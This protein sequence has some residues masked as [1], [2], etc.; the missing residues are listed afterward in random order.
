MAKIAFI[1]AGSFGFTRTLVKDVLSFP[2]L[3]NATL[4][5]MDIDRERLDYIAQAARKIIEKGGYP[6]KVETTM[7]RREALKGADAVICTILVDK[8]NLWRHDI[9]IPKKYGV[10]L[11]IGDSRGPAGIL[12]ALRTIPVMLDICRDMERYCPDALLLN[13]T[14]PMAMLCHAMQ[15]SSPLKIV[16]LCHSVQG[17]ARRLAGWINAPMP[18]VT[19]LCAGINHQAWFLEFK[20]NG[21]DVY[22]LIRKAVS[23]KEIY[24]KDIVRNEMFLHLGYFVTESSRHNSE[25]TWWFRKRPDLIRKYCISGTSSQPGNYGRLVKKY[26]QRQKTWRRQIKEWLA[27]KETA[28][29]QRSEEYAAHIINAYLGGEMF[30]FNGNVPNTGIIP[31]LPAGACVE[32]PLIANKR[33]FA[34]LYVG[35]LPPQLAALTNMNIAVEKM[36]VEAILAGDVRGIFH[37][38]A[39]DPLT[40]SV[41]SLA[42]IKKMA[43]EMLLKNRRYLAGFKNKKL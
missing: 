33:G 3:K 26:I 12:R 1:G 25:Y 41:L 5:L 14:N 29:V 37:A 13:Y 28:E 42:E 43:N 8:L 40:A 27:D 38:M 23:K 4:A 35:S 15:R 17:T 32:V 18:E 19:Y 11:C 30:E 2:L 36:A 20:H 39:Y 24:D 7:E 31:N 6:A 9:E 22:P 10:D 21:R 16:G 34:P